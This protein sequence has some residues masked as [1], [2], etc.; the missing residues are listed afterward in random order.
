MLVLIFISAIVLG[1][2][3]FDQVFMMINMTYAMITIPTLVISIQLCSDT[4]YD[5]GYFRNNNVYEDDDVMSKM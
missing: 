3:D 2:T 4:K 5:V 1:A